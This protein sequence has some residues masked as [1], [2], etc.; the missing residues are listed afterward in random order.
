MNNQEI[1]NN[2]EIVEIDLRRVFDALLNKAWL[3]VATSVV[4]ALGPSE[5]FV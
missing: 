3:I 5:N 4:T 2:E 1:T